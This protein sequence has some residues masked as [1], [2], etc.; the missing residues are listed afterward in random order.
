[1][2]TFAKTSPLLKKQVKLRQLKLS[3][4]ESLV[5]LHRKCFP[6]MLPWKREQIESQMQIFPEGQLCLEAEGKL[7]AS[8]NSLITT[9]DFEK[10]HRWGE[11]TDQGYIRNHDP[12]GESLYGI[13]IMVD[14]AFQ[15]E[16]LATQLY[17]ARK[18]L[19]RK[20]GLKR[21]VI[22]G[23]MPGYGEV[24]S[25]MTPETYMEKVSKGERTDPVLTP[26]FRNGFQ[27]LKV[28]PNYFPLDKESLGY[29]VLLEWRNE[30]E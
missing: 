14:P 24:S 10:D 19:V 28:L 4:Y 3:D 6:G 18:E 27:P 16:G 30:K 5:A 29:A 26:Q 23:R 15:G 25:Q 20:L 1:M 8:S 7:V 13:E 11:A 9:I 21:I 2:S 17:Q 22:A 12:K